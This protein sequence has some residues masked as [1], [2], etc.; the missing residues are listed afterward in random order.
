MGLRR[1]FWEQAMPGWNL[2]DDLEFFRGKRWGCIPG[3]ALVWGTTHG[4]E[5][6]TGFGTRG[7]SMWTSRQRLRDLRIQSSARSWG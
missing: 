2:R 6:R 4:L 1:G 3:A 5:G 7:S